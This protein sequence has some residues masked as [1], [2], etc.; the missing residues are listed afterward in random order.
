MNDKV[1]YEGFLQILIGMQ[2]LDIELKSKKQ[3]ELVY[4]FFEILH[5]PG[6]KEK[7]KD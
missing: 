7:S 6:L 4:K 3:S 5:G 2:L 1:E